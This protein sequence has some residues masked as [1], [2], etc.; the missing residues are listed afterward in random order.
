MFSLAPKSRHLSALSAG[1]LAIAGPAALFAQEA[2]KTPEARKAP[3]A[4]PEPGRDGLVKLAELPERFFQVQDEAGFLWQALDNGALLAGESQYFQ[5]GLNLI[6]DGNPFQPGTAQASESAGSEG[7]VAVR[8]EESRESVALTRELWFDRKRSGVRVWDRLT[9]PGTT[10][11]RYEVILRTTYPFAWQSL[12][13][14]GG[15]LL[16]TEPALRPGDLSLAVHFSPSEGRHDTIFILGSEKGGQ[17][18]EIKA[19]ANSRELAFSY[20]VT[21]PPGQSRSLLHWVLQRNLSDLS[22][23]AAALSP[24]LQGGQWI[25]A[26]LDEKAR[27]SVV[28]LAPESFPSTPVA[29]SG[30]KGL[31]ALNQLTDE[32]GL[33]RRGEDMLWLGP[34]NGIA[35]VL[36]RDGQITLST[37][38][39]GEVEIP[40][41]RIA[42]IRG[43]AER[44]GP[45]VVYLRDGRVYS[46]SISAGVLTWTTQGA[47]AESLDAG[48]FHL[49]L[50]A[51][52]AEDGTLPAGA[53]H[54]L[55]LTSGTVLAIAPEATERLEWASPQG[56]RSDEWSK[57]VELRRQ[58]ESPAGWRS[59][60]QDGSSVTILLRAAPLRVKTVGAGVLELPPVL[61]DRLWSAGTEP[62]LKQMEGDA[63]LD[64][65]ELPAGIGPQ[66]GVL[67]RGNQVLAA[68]L[69]PGSLVLVDGTTRTPVDTARITGLLRST[70]PELPRKVE[71]YLAGGERLVGEIADL[72]LAFVRGGATV[73]IP[74]GSILSYRNPSSP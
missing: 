60:W 52:G 16:G 50:L 55:Q 39:V 69:A 65:S 2:Q 72:S 22:E 45:V 1:F 62:V 5:S 15:G 14:T 30:L 54:F 63:L 51:T 21:V 13:G 4:A 71:I 41:A 40:F 43:A 8:L 29:A 57:L 27:A 46:G 35:G 49:L 6:V 56:P 17:V 10:E 73:E 48:A 11:R 20:S 36:N 18:P 38:L 25:D 28:N 12:H 70:D 3:E 23:D 33:Y 53:T 37:A 74:S 42:A 47:V 61:V 64:F 34:S 67:L 59:R 24:F 9:N 32:T 31:V 19:S 7:R 66:T 44:G 58:R 68:E 26:G